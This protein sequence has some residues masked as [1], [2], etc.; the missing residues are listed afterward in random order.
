MPLVLLLLGVAASVWWL[1]ASSLAEKEFDQAI[2]AEASRGRAWSCGERSIGGFPF[3]IEAECRQ[4]KLIILGE[5]PITITA[6]RVMALSQI[7]QPRLMLIEIAAPLS[8]VSSEGHSTDMNWSI[9][10]ASVHLETPVTADRISL[11]AKDVVIKSTAQNET[12]H[13]AQIE[14]HIRKRPVETGTPIDVEFAA[15]VAKASL[16]SIAG[17]P[18]DAHIAGRINQGVALLERSGTNAIETWRKAD[19]KLILDQLT[20][21][22]GEQNL[23]VT[24]TIS[25]DEQRRPTGKV[26][27]AAT[28]LRDLLK[29]IGMGQLADMMAGD[30]RLPLTMTKGRLLLGPL[31][32][33]DLQP[34]Y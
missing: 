10:R 15:D 13:L 8:L 1:V 24:G 23:N 22:R 5:R 7:Y 21:N 31:K 16:D 12:A 11:E 26:D 17:A 14:T 27:V 4:A 19:G 28:G 18:L 6:S 30:V 25:L 9:F 29:E 33:A 3:R 34:L 32:L 20:V 2:A